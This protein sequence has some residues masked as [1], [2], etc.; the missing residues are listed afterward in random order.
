MLERLWPVDIFRAH[1]KALSDYRGKSPVPDVLTRALVLIAP[2]AAIVASLVWRFEMQL[3]EGV[4]AAL[5]LLAGGFLAAFTH[6][7]GVRVRLAEREET[8]GDAERFER[9]AIDETSAHLLAGS[10]V[11]G[12]ATMVLLLG[13]NFGAGPRPNTIVGGWAAVEAGLLVYLALIFLI[14][15]PRL[16]QAYAAYAGV[17][18][19]LSG[20][21]R[22]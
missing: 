8:W 3:P 10:Y 16:Y 5:A 6:L 13:M 20:T 17:R 22:G 14:T 15:L 9:D 7:S 18:A 1:W 12:V 2:I 19:E 4:L 21:H 11:S